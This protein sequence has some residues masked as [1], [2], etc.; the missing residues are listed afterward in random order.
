VET[1]LVAQTIVNVL[2]LSAM[3]VLVALG[4]ALVLN[5]LGVLNFAHAAIYTV[6]GYLCFF[7]ASDLGLN[8]WMAMLLSSLLMGGFGLGLERLFFR[9]LRGDMNRVIVV[10]L[11]L[12][13]ILTAL[14]NVT[15][16]AYKRSIPPFVEGVIT[17]G[18]VSISGERLATF[19]IGLVL[20]SGFWYFLKKNR[21][22]LQMLAIAQDAE[23]AA[24][25]GININR[26]AAITTALGCALAAVAGSLM[27]AILALSPSVGG[28]MLVKAIEI[29]IMAGIGSFGG[30]LAAGLVLGAVDATLPLFFSGYFTELIGLAII[31]VI[32]LIRP[33]GLFG[34]EA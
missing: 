1:A 31:I 10:T 22:G 6:G 20:L 25:Q 21:I 24:L 8:V 30:V 15:V 28:Q 34:H 13:V 33:Q 16:G 32:L 14:I 12:I 9:V 23:G 29:V 26:I 5:V 7:F 4:F 27:G 18:P 19:C 3:Y 17:L 2:M 11:A